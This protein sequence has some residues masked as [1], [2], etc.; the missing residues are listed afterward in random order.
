MYQIDKRD[1]LT[2]ADVRG[3]VKAMKKHEL[4]GGGFWYYLC[5]SGKQVL[6]PPAASPDWNI[7]EGGYG[8]K[9]FQWKRSKVG[10]LRESTAKRI[11]EL[12]SG[13]PYDERG[14]HWIISTHPAN[15]YSIE[16]GIRDRIRR[17]GLAS[18]TGD[19]INEWCA[20]DE[21]RREK[22]IFTTEVPRDMYGH[23]LHH[24][25]GTGWFCLD[26][27][28]VKRRTKTFRKQFPWGW[29]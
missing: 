28:D 13:A 8:R 3:I 2:P 5:A 22:G 18:L 9:I 1:G 11:E 26:C 4:E 14:T 19:E 10:K 29:V 16:R 24:L 27:D 25:Q 15:A 23:P 6:G 20:K 12:V 17:D 21:A 7:G